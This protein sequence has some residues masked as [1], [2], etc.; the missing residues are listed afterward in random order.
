MCCG[1]F[2]VV[3]HTPSG[4]KRSGE[5][6]RHHNR[7]VGEDQQLTGDDQL[8]CQLRHLRYLWRE[9]QAVVLENVLFTRVMVE[10]AGWT[11]VP[12]WSHSRGQSHIQR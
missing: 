9:V 12:R 7:P 8:L 11:G 5:L 3:Q 1:S 2:C 4:D 6:L 10:H